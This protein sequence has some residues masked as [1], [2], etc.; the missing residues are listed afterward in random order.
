[1]GLWG[2]GFIAHLLGSSRVWGEAG[3]V[4]VRS[5]HGGGAVVV[6]RKGTRGVGLGLAA[7]LASWAERVRE[8]LAGVQEIGPGSWVSFIFIFSISIFKF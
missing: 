3:A 8:G 5:V 2:R 1:M 4:V 6:W 7:G